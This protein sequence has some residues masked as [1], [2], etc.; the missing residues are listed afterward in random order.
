MNLATVEKEKIVEICKRNDIEFC[1]LFGSFARGEA[2]ETS[3]I[4]LLVRF[5][6]PIGWA[7]YGVADELEKVLGRKV[8]LATENMIGK[9]IRES[10]YR[11]LKVIYEETK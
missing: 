6:K 1:A 4:D 2:D 5:S 3:D 8:D 11:D 10:V 7:F 9:R